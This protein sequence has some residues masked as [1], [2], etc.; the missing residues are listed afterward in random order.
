[1][2]PILLAAA[3]RTAARR[4][5]ARSAAVRATLATAAAQ[6]P[7]F[8]PGQMLA[9]QAEVP[10]LPIPSLESSAAVYLA[11]VRPL[12]DDAAYAATEANVRAFLA[13]GGQGELLQARLRDY[14]AAQPNSWLEDFWLKYAYLVWRCPTVLNVNWWCQF[15]D[16]STVPNLKVLDAVPPKGTFTDV[17]LTRA[18]GIV[19]GMLDANAVIQAGALPVDTIKGKPLCMNQYT[20]LFGGNRFPVEGCDEIVT[21]YPSH[22]RHIV[23]L[24]RDQVVR[25]DV[26]GPKGERPSVSAIRA[27]LA[28]AVETATASSAKQQPPIGVL[29]SEDRDRWAVARKKLEAASPTNRA[30]FDVI[31]SALFAVALD[32]V[33]YGVTPEETHHQIFHNHGRNRW[34]DKPLVLCVTNTGRAGVSGEH[35][36]SDAVV[37][38][39]VFN[40]VLAQEAALHANR[41]HSPSKTPFTLPAPALLTWDL[42]AGFDATL[43]AA[44]EHVLANVGAVQS[45]LLHENSSGGSDW[46]KAS[47]KSSPDSYAQMALQLAY[48]RDRGHVPATYESASTRGYLHG[49][50]E[51]VRSQSV[52]SRDFVAAFDRAATSDAERVALLRAATA[53]H[54]QTMRQASAGLGCDRHWLGLKLML[55]DGEPVPAMMADPAFAH[56]Q[57]FRLSTS[58]MTPGKYIYGGFGAVAADGYGV[59]YA[60]DPDSFKFSVS[61]WSGAGTDAR[62]M[63]DTLKATLADLYP[64]V[65][66]A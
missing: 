25:L 30:T 21:P 53:T 64:V 50:T 11:S 16:P 5:L 57:T 9:R 14:D 34:F 32:D 47:A 66:R 38:G 33:S 8:V 39:A 31:D 1:M 49:R 56:S 59:N 52:A 44:E 42:P 54:T 37:P 2:S 63:R 13:P 18:A 20:K 28:K 51:C 19:A 4:S 61:A 27:A 41:D 24:V 6:A 58:N 15:V 17:Q 40:A 7:K 48:F 12:L 29:T 65:N 26:L 62:R 43:R 55:R 22:S 35:S 10:R 36:P 23:V 45:A 60:V 46:I 3:A